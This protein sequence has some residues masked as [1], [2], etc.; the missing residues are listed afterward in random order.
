MHIHLSSPRKRGRRGASQHGMP[1]IHIEST[2]SWFLLTTGCL[3]DSSG[4]NARA[5]SSTRVEEAAVRR[6]GV[7]GGHGHAR[8]DQRRSARSGCSARCSR[9]QQQANTDTADKPACVRRRGSGRRPPSC[10]AARDGAAAWRGGLL[11]HVAPGAAPLLFLG[12]PAP[13]HFS[14]SWF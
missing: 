7:W 1:Q 4:R 9:Q 11:A 13:S 5:C 6:H 8:Q 3:G 2:A 10:T 14:C 12:L